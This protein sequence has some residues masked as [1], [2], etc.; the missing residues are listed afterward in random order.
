[1]EWK[2]IGKMISNTVPL[3]G[4][5]LAPITG[6]SSIAI[7]GLISAALGTSND[8]VAISNE[9]KN[10]P[11]AMLKLKQL[12]LDNE[13]SLRA[14]VIRLNEIELDKYKTAHDTYK[15]NGVE[16]NSIAESIIN[17]NLPIIAI[18]V[19][20]NIA[21]VYLMED[22]SE[23]IAIASNIIG[24]AIGNLFNERQAIINFIFG[25]SVGSKEKDRKI[26]QLSK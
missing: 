2:D 4:T 12:E 15:T 5:L 6:G 23:L 22:R 7:G 9:L 10:N 18:L 8:A 17:Y 3:L 16:A 14:Q 26:D 1:M 20:V 25:S 24:V 13:D 11:E 21:L 19:L